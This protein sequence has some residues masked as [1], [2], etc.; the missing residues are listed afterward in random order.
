M[1]FGVKCLVD[2]YG[3]CRSKFLR[4]LA[5]WTK[6]R[7]HVERLS[8][9]EGEG[10]LL[11]FCSFGSAVSTAVLSAALLAARFGDRNVYRSCGQCRP[12]NSSRPVGR[13]SRPAGRIDLH[14]RGSNFFLYPTAF[15]AAESMI[16]AILE[17]PCWELV[18]SSFVDY[19]QTVSGSASGPAAQTQT[20]CMNTVLSALIPVG[21][22]ICPCPVGCW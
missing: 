19:F 8:D 12:E 1:L 10:A 5:P 21:C 3:S 16:E 14:F 15:A 18:V 7:T 17:R 13:H 2:I 4:M 6:T 22:G 11:R 20:A 9:N